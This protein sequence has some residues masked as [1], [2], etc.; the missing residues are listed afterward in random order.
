MKKRGNISKPYMFLRL[1]NE[2]LN[3]KTSASCDAERFFLLFLAVMFFLLVLLGE[4]TKV[5]EYVV[6]VSAFNWVT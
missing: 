4:Y 2:P 5:S 3:W 1:N 6:T